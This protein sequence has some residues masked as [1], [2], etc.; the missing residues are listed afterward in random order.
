M[1]RNRDGLC[2]LGPWLPKDSPGP[3]GA[4]GLA[5]HMASGGLASGWGWGSEPPTGCVRSWSALMPGWSCPGDLTRAGQRLPLDMRVMGEG[6]ERGCCCLVP[7]SARGQQHLLLVLAWVPAGGLL[8]ELRFHAWWL[9]SFQ[10]QGWRL[11]MKV[12]FSGPHPQHILSIAGQQM[13]RR[14]QGA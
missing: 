5:A 1:K 7:A 11:C 3:A 13:G 10:P 8:W 14:G 2:G 6:A 4:R 9:G 12:S